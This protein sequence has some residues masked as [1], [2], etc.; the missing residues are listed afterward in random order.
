MKLYDCKPA[1]SP[2]RVRIFLA[3]KG[4]SLPV[5]PVDLR[6]GQ[7]FAEAFL[8]RNPWG[9]VPV[10]ELDDGTTIS[11]A[12]ACCRYIEELYPEPPLFGRT[13]VEKSLVQMW[14]HRAEVDGF[15]AVAEA[16]R[17][18]TPGMKGRALPGPVG[19]EQIPALADRGLQ[20]I[21]HFM[22]AVDTHLAATP[23]LAGEAFSVA[24]ITLLVSIDFAGWCKVAV[25]PDHPH[26]ARWHAAVSARPSA[27]A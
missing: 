11:E 12:S 15:L 10:L 13:P 20:R 2:R 3:E 4:V 25:P 23:F 1:P 5:E 27:L 22:R 17:N 6:A 8:R 18:A 21:R 26:L 9:T 7:Q 19:Y 16:F 24:D 14:D